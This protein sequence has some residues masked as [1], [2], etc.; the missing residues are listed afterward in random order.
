MPVL[1]RRS[2]TE[3]ER[4]AGELSLIQATEAL[5]A[6]G[7]SYADLS[8]ARISERAGLTRTAFYFYFRDKRD[9]LMR[10]TAETAEGLFDEA[11]RWWS[12]TGG[13]ADLRVAL[14]NIMRSY[15]DHAALLRAV[16]EASSYDEEVGSYWRGL[17]D[18]FISATE[19]RLR[20]EGHQPASAEPTAFALIW[21]TE[22][23]CYQQVVRGGRLDDRALIDALQAIWERAVYSA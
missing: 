22:R 14:E 23:A 5:L 3:Q 7:S 13:P 4:R 8:I 16:V 11:D 21:M 17:I 2:Q 10:A 15:R 6:G 1:S 18:Q 20:A 19:R 12:G 9:L